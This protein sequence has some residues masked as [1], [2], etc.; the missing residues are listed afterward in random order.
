MLQFAP[1]TA[2]S[3]QSQTRFGVF[4]VE[5]ATVVG[6]RGSRSA[7]PWTARSAEQFTGLSLSDE[8]P[9]YYAKDDVI[10]GASALITVS[11]VL[12]EHRASR[13]QAAPFYV[14]AD[15][16]GADKTPA[17]D[18]FRQ[19]LTRLEEQQE[20]AM[21]ICPDA[22]TIDDPL[23][24][25]DLVGQIVTHCENFRRFAIVDAPDLADTDLLAGATPTC[26]APT[27]RCTRPTSNR[28]HRSRTRSPGSPTVPPSGFVAGRLRPHRPSTRG[29]QGAGQRAGDRHRRAHPGV[30][31]S[32]VRTCSTRAGST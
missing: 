3:D 23:L 28:H 11:R 14:T 22:L 15:K 8:H 9:Q 29:A 5:S 2:V 1:G 10:N 32:A 13:W 26:P 24:Q 6:R 31:A 21:V 12:R 30:H 7:C 17:N 4:S 25:A 19:G 27:P 16:I 20:P 18:D